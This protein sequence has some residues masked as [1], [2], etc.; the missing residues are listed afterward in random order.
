MHNYELG[1]AE[2][3]GSLRIIEGE[4]RGV[5]IQGQDKIRALH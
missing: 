1:V 5:A 3:L 2:V 4:T